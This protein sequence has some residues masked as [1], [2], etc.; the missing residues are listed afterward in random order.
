MIPGHQTRRVKALLNIVLR[1]A[2]SLVLLWFPLRHVAIGTVFGQIALVDRQAIL[3]ALMAI[4][5]STV[6]A[7]IRWTLILSALNAPR[8]MRVT[9]PLSLI[10][11]FFGQA[12]P[13]GVGGDVVRVWLACK[14][15]LTTR[16]AVSSVLADRL[17]GLLAIL[18]I[19]TAEL[20]AL[21][22]LVHNSTIILALIV[23]LA[24][25]YIG[26]MILMVLDKLS[27]TFGHLRVVR[28]LAAIS[29]DLR[30]VVLTPRVC[31]PVLLCG[32]AVQVLQRARGICARTRIASAGGSRKVFPYCTVR[33]R[34][35]DRANFDCGLGHSRELFCLVVRPDRRVRALRTCRL[36]RVRRPYHRSQSARGYSVVAAW[37][38]LPPKGPRN[39]RVSGSKR[40]STRCVPL[41]CS[42]PLH[43]MRIG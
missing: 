15:G 18:I 35:A 16:I 7:A 23:I 40:V 9:Y 11:V 34:F 28:G 25:G 31:L 26:L 29:A 2:V 10:G 42:E 3:A 19:V 12:L 22:T 21:G 41:V 17:T 39:N 13:A 4:I 6:V 24:I 5:A 32:A 30:A 37:Y 8:N 33:E 38:R 1:L 14:T 43:K 36:S 20:P 27:T